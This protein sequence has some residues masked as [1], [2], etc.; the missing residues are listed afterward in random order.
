MTVIGLVY[1]CKHL[2]GYRAGDKATGREKREKE[3]IIPNSEGF[4]GVSGSRM[5]AVNRPITWLIPVA[6]ENERFVIEVICSG[7][8]GSL[9]TGRTMKQCLLG[10]ERWDVEYTRIWR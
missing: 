2:V 7:E 10:D 9:I 8:G 5:E 4:E 6:K 1:I 3:Y